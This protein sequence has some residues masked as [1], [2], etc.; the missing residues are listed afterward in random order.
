MGQL[1]L[2]SDELHDDSCCV[3]GHVA[4]REN[5]NRSVIRAVPQILALL[6]NRVGVYDFSSLGQEVE[7]LG[8]ADARKG[9]FDINAKNAFCFKVRPDGVVDAS[10]RKSVNVLGHRKVAQDTLIDLPLDLFQQWIWNSKFPFS[11]AAFFDE[12]YFV[13]ACSSPD[14]L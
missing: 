9:V 8:G 11:A 6:A 2:E 5:D 3:P 14:T 4:R 13:G 12:Q 7:D 10:S 1:L